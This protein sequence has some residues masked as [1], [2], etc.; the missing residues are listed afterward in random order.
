MLL[1]A[2]VI[3][4]LSEAIPMPYLA[5]DELSREPVLQELHEAVV[6]LSERAVDV[7]GDDGLDRCVTA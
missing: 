1:E 3:A 5:A 2:E 7:N 4:E 6:V